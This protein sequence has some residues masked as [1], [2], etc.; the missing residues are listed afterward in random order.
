MT[1]NGGDYDRAYATV[2]KTNPALFAA[3]RAPAALNQPKY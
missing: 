3:M 1:A 2:Q